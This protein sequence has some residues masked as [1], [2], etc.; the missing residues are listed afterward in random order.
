MGLRCSRR[1][2]LTDVL[3]R[4]KCKAPSAAFGSVIHAAA[5]TYWSE[6]RSGA[7]SVVA[8]N[9]AR[10]AVAD[11]Y[12]LFMNGACTIGDH[13]MEMAAAMIDTYVQRA[14][15]AGP[16]T[17]S[18]EWQ[19]LLIEERLHIPIGD[20]VLSFMNDRQ[21]YNPQL[22]WRVLMDLK[23]AARMDARWRST[24]M[25]SLQMK[26]YRY[27]AL[28]WF[29]T[30]RT[31]IVIEGMSKGAKATLAYVPLPDWSGDILAEAVTQWKRVAAADEQI[32]RMAMDN[33][34]HI[35][36][37][38]LED[39]AV[40]QTAVNYHDCTAYGYSCPFMPL[41]SAEPEYRS[42]M[43]RADYSIVEQEY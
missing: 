9:A 17:S 20:Y 34:G 39:I 31:D 16:Y 40:T 4:G 23:T 32:I 41:C 30:A 33:D 5:A 37:A 14:E 36:M 18:G 13:T 38:A 1:H 2:V 22:D 26:L 28:E 29:D 42:G 3:E 11:S 15:I 27:A 12:P 8:V 6:L 21:A 25:M 19:L 35:D 10:A 43:L 7:A 24:W